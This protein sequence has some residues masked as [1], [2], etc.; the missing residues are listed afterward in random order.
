MVN[1]A[2]L[3]IVEFLRSFCQRAEKDNDCELLK[4]QSDYI[5]DNSARLSL[6][7][8]V[9][10]YKEKSCDAFLKKLD[11]TEADIIQ[12]EEET[13]G[14]HQNSLWYELRYGRVTASH[15]FEFSHCKT[16]DGTLISVIMGG[17]I[18]DT[19]AMKRGRILEEEVRKT[20]GRAHKLKSVD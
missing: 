16:I 1:Q 19:P 6:Q 11:L 9:M 15:A 3:Q 20:V 8:L 18:P 13:R 12:I 7:Q 10:K 17:K 4:Y 14:Q 2:C 5:S